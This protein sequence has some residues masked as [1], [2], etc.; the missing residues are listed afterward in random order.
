MT[1]LIKSILKEGKLIPIDEYECIGKMRIRKDPVTRKYF[2]GRK[3]EPYNPQYDACE[4]MHNMI[5][6]NHGAM[7]DVFTIKNGECIIKNAMLCGYKKNKDM[8]YHIFRT[9][10]GR[11]IL[12]YANKAFSTMGTEKKDYFWWKVECINADSFIEFEDFIICYD[13]EKC[14]VLYGIVHCST[15][16]QVEEHYMLQEA[17]TFY[18]KLEIVDVIK[19]K[20]FYYFI[21]KSEKGLGLYGMCWSHYDYKYNMLSGS[22][23]N[24]LVDAKITSFDYKDFYYDEEL[25]KIIAVDY[26]GLK[27]LIKKDELFRTT[28]AYKIK[29]AET[30]WGK[31][32]ICDKTAEEPILKSIVREDDGV[33]VAR[34]YFDF[35]DMFKG[36]R[37]VLIKD[38]VNDKYVKVT[39]EEKTVLDYSIQL[40][41]VKE[42]INLKGG[43]FIVKHKMGY[44]SIF[45]KSEFLGKYKGENNCFVERTCINDG[46][47]GYMLDLGEHRFFDGIPFAGKT[48]NEIKK[49]QEEKREKERKRLEEER[50]IEE[51]RRKKWKI[52]DEDRML[53]ESLKG[54]SAGEAPYI[55]EITWERDSEGKLERRVRFE[56]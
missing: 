55:A 4:F 26:N 21:V 19:K 20:F 9:E 14:N 22:N 43:Y 42:I 29:Y 27:T 41:T 47:Y 25:K 23:I 12:L 44:Y 37:V 24:E 16:Y 1:E 56:Y 50:I 53:L 11:Q 3:E 40:N 51:R 28:T 39:E 31:Y 54:P 5:F 15:K 6:A 7:Y 2:I 48:L 32:Y 36:F 45:Y 10:D 18:D 38:V 52:N 13:H 17:C 49:E 30:D 35:N 34:G 8:I 46:V 33:E